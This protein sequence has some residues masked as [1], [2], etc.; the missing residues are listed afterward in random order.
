[1]TEAEIIR[2]AEERVE[3]LID[4][5]VRPLERRVAELERELEEFRREMARAASAF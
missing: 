4:Q 5:R 2:R 3:K 1:M